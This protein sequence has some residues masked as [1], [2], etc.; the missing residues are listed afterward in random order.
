MARSVAYYGAMSFDCDEI[1][2]GG[3]FGEGARQHTGIVGKN[4]EIGHPCAEAAEQFGE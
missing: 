4:A 1:V 3:C 2:A